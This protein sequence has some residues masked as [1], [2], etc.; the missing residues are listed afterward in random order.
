MERIEGLA[1]HDASIERTGL[2]AMF[3]SFSANVFFLRRIQGG[4]IPLMNPCDISY[5]LVD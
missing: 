1:E 3:C 4:T 5:G 2:A